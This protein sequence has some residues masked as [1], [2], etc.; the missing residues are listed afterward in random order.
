[1]YARAGRLA[2][3]VGRRLRPIGVFALRLLGALE[4]RTRGTIAWATRTSTRASAVLT[5]FRAVASVVVA[6]SLCLL[7]A[8]FVDYR[9]VE[10][11]QPG[12]AGLGGIAQAPVVGLETPI[13]AHSF[14]LVPIALLGAGLG[15]WALLAGRPRLGRIVIGLGAIAVAVVLIVDLPAGLDLSGQANRFSGATAVLVDGFYAQLAAAAGMMLGGALL[16][17]SP[18]AKKK[19]AINNRRRARK[20]RLAKPDEGLQRPPATMRGRA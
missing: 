19:R 18:A 1:V 9:G 7:A 4:K 20:P 13:D 17:F 16:L 11:G 3:W 12:Y 10:V 2:R 15:L 14:A 8:Q 6:S 5:P